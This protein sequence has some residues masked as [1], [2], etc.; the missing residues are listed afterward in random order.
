M[1]HLSNTSNECSQ[2]QVS[3]TGIMATCQHG[4]CEAAQ[5]HK[6]SVKHLLSLEEATSLC[7][8][9]TTMMANKEV[10]ANDTQCEEE[11]SETD[12]IQEEFV[13]IDENVP[14]ELVEDGQDH[15]RKGCYHFVQLW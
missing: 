15:T 1:I 6:R 8:H 13:T 10:W 9:L 5:K 12:E 14:I 7:E 11:D 2:V 3:A 4:R